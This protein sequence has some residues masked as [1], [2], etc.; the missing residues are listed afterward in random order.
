[1]INKLNTYEFYIN[2][3]V[4]ENKGEIPLSYSEWLR[5]YGGK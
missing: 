5:E 3:C 2:W 4:D 1:M